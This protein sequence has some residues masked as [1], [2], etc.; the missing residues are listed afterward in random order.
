[1]RI[2]TEPKNAMV[3]QYS[4]LLAMDGVELELKED[5][6]EA[7]AD[8]ALERGT[9]ARALRSIFEKLMLDVMFESPSSEETL[10]VAIDRDV[11]DGT[12]SA[13]MVPKEKKD[14]A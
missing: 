2:L 6:L 13:P 11:V 12:K 10:A 5:G 8:Q 4:K 14:A 3:K 9:G 7:M 1:M